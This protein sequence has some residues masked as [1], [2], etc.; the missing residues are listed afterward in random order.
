[1][2][3]IYSNDSTLMSVGERSTP[4]FSLYVLSQWVLFSDTAERNITLYTE[5]LNVP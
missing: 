3:E 4:S 5:R 2:A 1:M